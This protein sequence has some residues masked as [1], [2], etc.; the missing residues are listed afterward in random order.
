[1]FK[2][3]DVSER[4]G[5]ECVR[6]PVNNQQFHALMTTLQAAGKSSLF[7]TWRVGDGGTKGGGQ[8]RLSIHSGTK[9]LV[10]HIVLVAAR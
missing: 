8:E 5:E 2:S 6:E 1:M 9:K 7:Q 3:S 10:K 4:H